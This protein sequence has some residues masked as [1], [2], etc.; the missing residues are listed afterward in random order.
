MHGNQSP[1]TLDWNPLP[2]P[3]HLFVD[4]FGNDMP[5]FLCQA[6]QRY[7]HEYYVLGLPF[8]TNGFILD[9]QKITAHGGCILAE[10]V[11]SLDTHVVLFPPQIL[12]VHPDADIEDGVWKAQQQTIKYV[13]AQYVSSHVIKQVVQQRNQARMDCAVVQQRLERVESKQTKY[14]ESKSRSLF[15]LS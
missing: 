9:P 7:V 10:Y 6:V 5:V 13:A 2:N 15:Q 4:K 3:G 1:K 12:Q 11:N 14:V 8:E